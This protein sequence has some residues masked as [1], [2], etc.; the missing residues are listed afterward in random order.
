MADLKMLQRRPRHL[1]Q[2]LAAMALSVVLDAEPSAHAAVIGA[3]KLVGNITAAALDEISGIVDCHAIANV[4]WVHND[5]GDAAR[6][7]SITHQGALLGTHTL[8]SASAQDWEDMAIGP[9]PGGGHYLYLAD[10]GDNAPFNRASIRIYRTAEPATTASASIPQAN[11]ATAILQYPAGARNAEA[12]LVDPLTSEMFIIIKGAT[13]EIYS[14][15]ASAFGAASTNLVA[16]GVLGGS[17]TGVTAADISPDGRH[18]VVRGYSA[19]R[20]YERAEGQ[21][22]ADALHAAGS[23]FTLGNEA[24]GE[25][26]GWAADGVN[27]YTTSEYAGGTSAPIYRYSYGAPQRGDFNDDGAVDALDFSRWKTNFPAGA[28]ADADEDHD[29]DGRDFLVWQRNFMAQNPAAPAIP[30]PATPFLLAASAFSLASARASHS[31]SIIS[32][33]R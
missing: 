32:I 27:F 4:F 33:R 17:L 15:P 14:A 18:I 23:A 10:I 8:S 2:T 24:Q 16:R 3:P 29:S 12:F 21:S 13:S 5:S 1:V 11:Y 9:H 26:I 31:T 25:A 28:G 19:A 22:L 20:Q 30:E 6:F 7:Y